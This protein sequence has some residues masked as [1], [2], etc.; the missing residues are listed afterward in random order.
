MQ[1]SLT[2]SSPSESK[3]NNKS[4][5]IWM[6]VFFLC[7]GLVFF[8][9]YWTYWRFR[10]ST[11]DA[12]VNGN[13]VVVTTQIPG[14]VKSVSVDDTDYVTQGTPL[15]ILDA[16]DPSI[17][18][19]KSK[20]DLAEIIRNVVALFQRVGMLKADKER[21]KA[22]MIRAAQDYLH[23]Q[24]L[25]GSGGVSKEDFEHAEADFI[26]SVAS[27]MMVEHE[28]KSGLAQVENTT[29]ETHPLVIKAKEQLIEAYVNFQRCKVFAPVTG[30]VALKK[31]QVGQAVNSMDPLMA[32]IPMDQMWVDANFKETQLRC[33]RI[34][35]PVTMTAD[36]YG[37]QVV[38]HG[39]IIGI[40]G[41]TGSVFS[42]LPPQNATG[43]WIKIV[44]RLP[45]RISLD[46]EEIQKYP[47]RLGLSMH[48]VVDIRQY[49]G[50]M[51]PA[52]VMD[53]GRYKTEIFSKLEAG[54]QSLIQEILQKNLSFSFSVD[55]QEE[56]GAN[57]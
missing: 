41:G 4:I 5:L 49:E 3:K 39:K 34:G 6:G 57:P 26:A 36:L 38:Y 28:L 53:T 10:E 2:S 27:L 20:A 48:V 13:M 8:M 43:N 30:L 24:K 40:P 51:V 11:K 19:E 56:Q 31:V 15:V 50:P 12:Y 46:A 17:A 16:T 45:V 25:L 21:K 29:V 44:Q 1:Q 9:L 7:I 54:A 52:P 35:Q 23:R 37:P 22:Q 47:L 33:M 14:Y 55:D 32:V 42:P 18:L